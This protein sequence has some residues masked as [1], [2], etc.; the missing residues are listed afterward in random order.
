MFTETLFYYSPSIYIVFAVI[1]IQGFIG[2]SGYVNTFYRI[3]DEVAE[4]KKRFAMGLTDFADTP[5]L[6]LVG[7][8]SK[9]ENLVLKFL[10]II[11]KKILAIPVHDFICGL[12]L[13]D[14]LK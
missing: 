1:L 2:G 3:T 6:T 7:F 8:M 12:P 11:S 14:R 5:A 4:D 13:P 10:K 9:S